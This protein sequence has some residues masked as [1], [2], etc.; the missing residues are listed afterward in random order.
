[1][2]G[3][4]LFRMPPSHVTLGLNIGKLSGSFEMFF[5]RC[6]AL[7]TGVEG[8]LSRYLGSLLVRS[9]LESDSVWLVCSGASNSH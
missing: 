6:M 7:S 4:R 1:M 2:T 5:E 9:W 3:N 8:D